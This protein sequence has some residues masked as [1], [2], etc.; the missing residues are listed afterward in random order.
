MGKMKVSLWQIVGLS[1]VAVFMMFPTVMA[2]E[3]PQYGGV[4]KIIDLA[5]GAQPIGAPWMVRGIDSKLQKPV[6]E[7]FIR[8][9]VSGNYKPWLATSWKI[10]QA[11]NTITLFLRKGVKFHDGTDFNAQAAKWTI[12]KAIEAKQVK[13]FLSADVV[14]DYTVRINVQKY[15]N[16]LLNLLASSMCNPVSPTAYEKNGEEWAKWHPVG[17]G[18]FKFV[19]FERG[20]KLTYTRWDGY[21]RKGEPY[22]DGIE[23]LFIRDPM[24]QQAAMR[25]RGDERVDVLSIT[26]GEQAAMMQAQGFN[27]IKMP[28][29]PVSLI[30]Q[31]DYRR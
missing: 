22:L 12:D 24:T 15:Q 10:D 16:N 27:V 31:V 30:P 7:S 29:G 26:S 6:V 28:V 13:G 21:W 14:D 25:A 8:E 4:L 11:N 2:A 23:Y 5:E 9:T 20:D 3:T 17:T 18:P 19:S 1:L